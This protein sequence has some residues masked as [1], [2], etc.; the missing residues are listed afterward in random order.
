MKLLFAIC[1]GCKTSITMPEGYVS[2]GPWLSAHQKTC[3]GEATPKVVA[4]VRKAKKGEPSGPKPVNVN[5]VVDPAIQTQE[6][7]REVGIRAGRKLIESALDN[8]F[9]GRVK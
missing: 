4:R 9:N 7:L 8:F 6:F 2:F 1:P 3:P 5:V